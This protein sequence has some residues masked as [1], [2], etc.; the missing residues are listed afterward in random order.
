MFSLNPT[1]KRKIGAPAMPET[2]PDI[3]ASLDIAPDY[4]GESQEESAVRKALAEIEQKNPLVGSRIA[5]ARMCLSLAKNI[6]KGNEKGR[7]VA[8]EVATLS[9]LMD[10]L[11]PPV[12]DA[13]TSDLPPE[14]R[15]IADALATAPRPG[16]PTADN[17]QEL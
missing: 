7:A 3:L 12:I 13:D 2:T 10:Q 8:N 11:D 14:L 1:R 16:G 15:K 6:A 9:Q 5:L 17:S 4:Y